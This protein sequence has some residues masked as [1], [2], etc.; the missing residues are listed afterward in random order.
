MQVAIN[1]FARAARA[2]SPTTNPRIDRLID[3]IIARRTTRPLYSRALL[4]PA[5]IANYWRTRPTNNNLSKEEL[6]AKALTIFALVKF[7]RPSDTAHLNRTYM[8]WHNNDAKCTFIKWGFKNNHALMG[9]ARFVPTHH[10]RIV[11]PL[12][13]L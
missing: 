13:T 5:L 3:T 8:H 11:C 7:L 2:T 6:Q 4:D 12:S 10:K 9:N 1:G